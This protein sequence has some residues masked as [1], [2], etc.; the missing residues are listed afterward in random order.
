[1]RALLHHRQFQEL[2]AAWRGVD[3]LLRNVDTDDTLEVCLLDVSRTELGAD[4]R[5][6]TDSGS[7]LVDLLVG[8]PI[9]SRPWSLIVGLL[10]FD[11]ADDD[12]V[13]LLA[14]LAQVAAAARAPVLAAA[15][16]GLLRAAD[17]GA[18][19]AS[20]PSDAWQALRSLAEAQYAGLIAPRFLLRLPYGRSTDPIDS[21]AFEEMP[22]RREA[23]ALLWG[24][25]AL[26][27]ASLLAN[28]WREDGWGFDAPDHA[29]VSGLPVYVFTESGEKHALPC[30]EVLLT[31]RMAERLLA[32]GVM[33]LA[34]VRDRDAVQIVRFQSIALPAAPLAGL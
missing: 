23:G 18:A 10:A 15:G 27:G 19:S 9:G 34:S 12:D 33:P 6:A 8:Q 13:D 24:S 11:P 20:E 7:G 4:L 32:L 5:N 29:T 1:M 17:P 26:A 25:P 28:A 21:F 30:G 2:E 31:D 14:R 22:G 3:F 16:A